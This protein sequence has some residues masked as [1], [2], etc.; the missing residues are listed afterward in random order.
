M[1]SLLFYFRA[2]KK[3]LDKAG[4]ARYLKYKGT[5]S[6]NLDIYNENNIYNPGTTGQGSGGRF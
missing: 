4:D 5:D 2:I 3:N 6:E 1:D